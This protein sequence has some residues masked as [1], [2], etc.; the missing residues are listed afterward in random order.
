[1][2][3]LSRSLG[4]GLPSGLAVTA[5]LVIGDAIFLGVAMIGLAAI[6]STMGPMFQVVKYAGGAYL[7]WLGVQAVGSAG[8]R[9][10][11]AADGQARC[12]RIR[13]GLV[14]TLNSEAG[15]VLCALL[16]TF[17]DANYAERLYVPRR[18][19]SCPF[20]VY[21]A[22]CWWSSGAA[23]AAPHIP[24]A[25][26]NH[27]RHAHRFR[28][29]RGKPVKAGCLPCPEATPPDLADHRRQVRPDGICDAADC[30]GAG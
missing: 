2:A 6:A 5:G 3:I 30:D 4:G 26:Q 8:A 24:P 28:H 12:G 1:V 15:P 9:I 20:A 23:A 18:S 14:V 13:L 19:S 7:V 21:S 25:A 22:T 27:R 29:C 10:D 17:L 11:V 16:P